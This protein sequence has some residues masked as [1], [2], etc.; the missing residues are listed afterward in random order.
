[1]KPS[2]EATETVHMPTAVLVRLWLLLAGLFTATALTVWSAAS[3]F[4]EWEMNAQSLREVGSVLPAPPVAFP[5]QV[6]LIPLGMALAVVCGARLVR[7][8]GYRISF[9]WGG[10]IALAVVVAAGLGLWYAAGTTSV[11]GAA[12]GFALLTY[13]G[14]PVLAVAVLV[15]ICAWS[16]AQVLRPSSR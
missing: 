14:G 2:F 7:G 3:A 11:I 10:C 5:V 16:L 8:L 4:A 1:M 15:F 9:W 6:A 12:M 13:I